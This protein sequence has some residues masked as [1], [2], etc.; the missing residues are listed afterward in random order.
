MPTETGP[1]TDLECDHCGKRTGEVRRLFVGV[2][3]DGKGEGRICDE[4]VFLCVVAMA[5]EDREWVQKQLEEA[6]SRAAQ[7]ITDD[8]HG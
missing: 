5:L 6:L 4:C 7:A 3:W 8:S 1:T 2:R